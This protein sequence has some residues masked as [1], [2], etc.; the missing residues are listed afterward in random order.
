VKPYIVK[1]PENISIVAGEEI[2][3]GCV[4]GG[5]PPP[6]IRWWRQ[7][8]QLPASRVLVTDNSVLTV[9]NVVPDDEDVY[10]CQA[11]NS[12]GSVQ[13]VANVQIHCES[14]LFCFFH[15]KTNTLCQAEH[16]LFSCILLY[17]VNNIDQLST[18][19]PLT[20][21]EFWKERLLVKKF[22][23]CILLARLFWK[24]HWQFRLKNAQWRS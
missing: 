24:R 10:V 5:K 22:E 12:V 23:M 15:K 13:A 9:R 11:E 18:G 16:D 8:G 6:E 3:L 20:P 4:I 1:H 14:I 19:C 7:N 2:R 17:S 21:R